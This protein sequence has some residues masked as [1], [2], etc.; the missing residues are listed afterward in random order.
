MIDLSRYN[1]LADIQKVSLLT[2][3]EQEEMIVISTKILYEM[4]DK[5]KEIFIRLKKC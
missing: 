5:N 1:V 3:D 2:F 4:M